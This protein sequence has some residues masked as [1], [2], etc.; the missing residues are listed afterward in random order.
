MNEQIFTASNGI[1]VIY[2][3][4]P[5]KY[6]FKHLIIV[7]SGFLNATPGNY[8]FIN[9]MTDCPADVIWI[10]DN[11]QGMYTYYLRPLQNSPKSPKF[12]QRHLGDFP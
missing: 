7:F 4:K 12:P 1:E 10:N 9:A 3:H 8:D 5:S 2:R 6:D 11:F